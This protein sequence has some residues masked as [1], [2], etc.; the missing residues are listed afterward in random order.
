MKKIFFQ[1]PSR[2]IWA[3]VLAAAVGVFRYFTLAEGVSDWLMWYEIFSVSGYV[4]F[5][6]GALLTVAY[7]GAFD[8][9]G[10]VFSPG[11]TGGVKKYKNYAEYS[12]QQT[13][14]RAILSKTVSSTPATTV[15][16]SRADATTTDA[17]GT[18]PVKTS[19]FVDVP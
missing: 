7:F 5:L 9:F 19:S 18:S 14:K 8:L 10:Y 6:V 11:R 1:S 13:E 15:L 2:Y 4:T 3:L 17:S 12:Q 16:P